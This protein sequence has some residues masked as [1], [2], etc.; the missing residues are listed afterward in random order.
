MGKASFT[1]TDSKDAAM[2]EYVE[3]RNSLIGF[4]ITVFTESNMDH[5]RL[6]A[7]ID[8][9]EFLI[10]MKYRFYEWLREWGYKGEKPN[11]GPA[12]D[13]LI[14]S[15]TG[16]SVGTSEDSPHM[17]IPWSV[18]YKVKRSLPFSQDPPFGKKK[19]WKFK[20]CGYFKDDTN[21]FYQI[22]MKEWEHLIEFIII[23]RS[24]IQVDILTR[25]F[26][27]F[28]NTNHGY[29]Q[30]AGLAAMRPLGRIYENEAK[31]DDAGVHY[32]KTQFWA[33]SQQFF[34]AGP[35]TEITSIEVGTELPDF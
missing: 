35:F 30:G 10:Y 22:R 33:H 29:F 17:K 2:M 1:I 19:Q 9:T 26:E 11:F 8:I 6:P 23:S 24:N 7:N 18:A 31:L 4:D 5:L 28:A 12:Y 14:L 25:V 20:H 15:R 21:N 3:Y 16:E 13:D 27:N 32:R 34:V